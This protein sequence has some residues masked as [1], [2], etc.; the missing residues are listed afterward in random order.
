V[1]RPRERT[2]KRENR[3]KREP[4]RERTIKRENPEEREP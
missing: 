2:V 4:S 3:Q 1:A